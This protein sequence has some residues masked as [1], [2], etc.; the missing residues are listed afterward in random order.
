[1]SRHVHFVGTI[2]LDSVEEVFATAGKMLGTHL[3]RCPDGET[4]G[5]RQW[6]M[7]QYPFLRSSPYLQ[8]DVTKL[9]PEPAV[10]LLKLAPGVKAEAIHFGELGYAREA[11]VSYEDFLAARKSGQIP[12]K[13]RF[14]VCL[15]TPKAFMAFLTPE[16]A[17]AAEPAYE[18]AMVKEV[19]R[20][21]AAIPHQ[22][23]AI[24]WDVCFEMLMWDGRFPLMPRFPGIE[25]NFRQTFGRLC[26]VVPKDVQ[27]GV[28]LCYGDNDAKHFIDPLDLGKA[29]ELGNLII[30]NAGRPL[31]WIHMPVPA[32]RADDA[33][34]APL[35][36][37]HRSAG[38]PEVFLGLVHLADGVEGTRKRIASAAKVLPEFGIATECGM[39]RA[40]TREQVLELLGIH[41]GAAA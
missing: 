10:C 14:Q 25:A 33:Y 16:A 26:S 13:V 18:R 1:M 29:V 17:Q 4:G 15:P 19:E 12:A 37:L 40:R 22:D 27:L 28:H 7:W 9:V 20:I 21:C 38:R 5:R 34:F 36:D 11:R 23:L 39:A 8:A 3:L 32:N 6:V 35:K 30:D 24:Q 2:G 31:D 41:A